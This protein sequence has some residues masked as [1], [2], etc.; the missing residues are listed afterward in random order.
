MRQYTIACCGFVLLAVCGTLA[1]CAEAAHA[2]AVPDSQGAFIHLPLPLAHGTQGREAEEGEA[3]EGGWQHFVSWVAHFHPPLTVFPIAMILSAALAELLRLW[4]K[5]PW[6]AGASR[7]C[8]IVGGVGAAITAP[9]G[10]A[11]A[12]KHG[13][14]WILEVHRWLGTAAGTGAV[15][16]LVL[17]ELSWRRGGGLL[18][19]FRTVLFLAVPLVIATGFFGGAMVYGIHE[20]DWS[21]P[22]DQHTEASE[23]SHGPAAPATGTSS[24]SGV[25]EITMTDDDTFKPDQVTIPAGTTIRWKNTSKDAHTVTDDPHVA[26][27]VKDVASPAGTKPFNSGKIKPGGTFEQQFTIPGI[28]RYVCEPHE[29]MDMKGKVTVTA[30]DTSAPTPPAH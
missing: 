12:V 27:D 3:P 19:L 24:N 17:S 14:S 26:S 8:M 25:T 16:L 15:V 13:H 20:Y 6:L 9:L 1:F 4:S 7:W 21:R 11:F 23:T 18:T 2:A 22:A 28:Y 29:D 30:G 10:W 5:A